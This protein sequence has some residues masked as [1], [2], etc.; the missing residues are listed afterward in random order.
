MG[1]LRKKKKDA[2]EYAAMP[3]K[4]DRSAM[5]QPVWKPRT[6]SVDSAGSDASEC[7]QAISLAGRGRTSSHVDMPQAARYTVQ[8]TEPKQ[9]SFWKQSKSHANFNVHR[10]VFYVYEPG[11]DANVRELAEQFC[12]GIKARLLKSYPKI[13]PDVYVLNETKE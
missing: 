8:W 3:G 2:I 1:F 13:K 5:K 7:T 6:W 9:R 12:D 11:T 10:R 4:V